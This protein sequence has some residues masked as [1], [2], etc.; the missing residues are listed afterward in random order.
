MEIID[1]RGFMMS[2]TLRQ[3]VSK[4]DRVLYNT[5]SRNAHKTVCTP[6]DI[7]DNLCPPYYIFTWASSGAR[8]TITRSYK[9]FLSTIGDIGGVNELTLILLTLVYYLYHNRS[10]KSFMIKEV[11]FSNHPLSSDAE[12]DKD[13]ES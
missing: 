2:N 4:A 11:F 6:Q 8:V 10:Y 12:L 7:V 9:D 5:M 13:K 1:S 3:S